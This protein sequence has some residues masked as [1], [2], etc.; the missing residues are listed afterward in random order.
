MIPCSE[1]SLH[2]IP[3]YNLTT[4][5]LQDRKDGLFHNII[6]NTMDSLLEDSDVDI[7]CDIT[8]PILY[9]V[10]RIYVRTCL[11]EMRIKVFDQLKVKKKLAHRKQV[12]LDEAN[13]TPD[14]KR[15]KGGHSDCNE[16]ANPSTITEAQP[17]E[18]VVQETPPEN[19]CAIC[20]KEYSST[21]RFL[22][23]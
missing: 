20:S 4:R 12:L 6:E 13:P 1:A 17:E 14:A 3:Y 9:E 23:I 10:F 15:F 19:I 8:P 21:S 2:S 16:E 11:N 22:W 5:N 7:P 18:P